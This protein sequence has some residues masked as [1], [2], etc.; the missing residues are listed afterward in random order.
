[1]LVLLDFF[2]EIITFFV[3]SQIEGFNISEYKQTF[4]KC[5]FNVTCNFLE[6]DIES[7]SIFFEYTLHDQMGT[8]YSTALAIAEVLKTFVL[9]P[10]AEPA[11]FPMM[12]FLVLTLL[13]INFM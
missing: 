6:A 5:S 8:Q 10:Q 7:T 2:P 1:M 11:S 12:L 4:C 13:L 9:Q 3:S